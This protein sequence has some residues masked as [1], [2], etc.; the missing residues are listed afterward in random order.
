MDPA[1]DQLDH[2]VVFFSIDEACFTNFMKWIWLDPKD[3]ENETNFKHI[4]KY[5]LLKPEISQ[6]EYF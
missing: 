1:N 5:I 3:E 6:F 2:P 4:L